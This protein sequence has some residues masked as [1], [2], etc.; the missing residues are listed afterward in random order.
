MS[1]NPEMKSE[2]EKLPSDWYESSPSKVPIDLAVRLSELYPSVNQRSTP[3]PIC[4]VE[5]KG[6]GETSIPI[7]RVEYEGKGEVA[8]VRTKAHSKSSTQGIQKSTMS[9]SSGCFWSQFHF[10]Q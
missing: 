3:I 2:N 4:W 7:C 6:K 9:A 8:A 1:E 5:Y 10:E